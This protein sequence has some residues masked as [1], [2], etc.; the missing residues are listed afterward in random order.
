LT[1]QHEKE[2]KLAKILKGMNLQE[3]ATTVERNKQIG[4]CKLKVKPQN[5]KALT[6]DVREKGYNKSGR[7]RRPFRRSAC[8]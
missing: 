4:V 3:G 8:K 5:E 1:N 2:I 7:R 6:R